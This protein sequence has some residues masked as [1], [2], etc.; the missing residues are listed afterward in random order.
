MA[1][2]S[3]EQALNNDPPKTVQIEGLVLL[4]IIKHCQTHYSQ[5]QQAVGGRLLGL[6]HK[7]ILE[8]TNCFA[9]IN[10]PNATQK[11]I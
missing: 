4:R 11:K 7:T 8:V 2:F 5:Q 1:Q 10:G 9:S 6:Q 3:S